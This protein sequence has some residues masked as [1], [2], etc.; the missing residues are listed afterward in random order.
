[1]K[2]G[3]MEV[4]KL[5]ELEARLRQLEDVRELEE[6]VARHSINADL[7][8]VDEYLSLYTV[9]GCMD[10][11][12]YGLP[13]YE[14]RDRLREFVLGPGSSHARI[15]L[16]VAG[17]TIFYVEEN[18]AT[19][20]GYTIVCTRKPDGTNGALDG[21][22]SAPPE[23]IVSH[24]NYVHWEFARVNGEWKVTSRTVKEIASTSARDVFQRTTR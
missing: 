6:L 13:R 3:G 12:D 5:A 11:T 23:I 17:P 19:G 10:L 2:S 7:D 24:A 22:P 4:E 1:M 14:G 20:E 16:H 8:R 18:E 15:S 21:A 9:D